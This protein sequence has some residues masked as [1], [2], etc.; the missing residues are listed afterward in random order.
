MNKRKTTPSLAFNQVLKMQGAADAAI[1][2]ECPLNCF[3]TISFRS[4]TPPPI[5][6]EVMARVMK[7]FRDYVRARSGIAWFWVAESQSDLHVH[8]LLHLPKFMEVDQLEM[9]LKKW[10][11]NSKVFVHSQT[12]HIQMVRKWDGDFQLYLE[13][14]ARTMKYIFKGSDRDARRYLGYTDL[15]EEHGEGPVFGRRYVM[16]ESVSAFAQSRLFPITD[17]SVPRYS[18]PASLPRIFGES[19]RSV[20]SR[21]IAKWVED[22]CPPP[23]ND[24]AGRSLQRMWSANA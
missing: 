20:S 22:L 14:L 4:T 6:S 19:P 16:S 11:R 18:R 10:L 21:P 5:A 2:L 12:V 24:A 8:L 7:H 15:Q 9:L 1:Y 3:V 13:N 23:A 17:V